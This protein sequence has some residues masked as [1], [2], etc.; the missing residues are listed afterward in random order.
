MFVA[1]I[2]FPV[3]EKTTMKSNFALW[4]DLHAQNICDLV[5]KFASEL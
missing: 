1:A 4:V 5:L 3:Y 2:H